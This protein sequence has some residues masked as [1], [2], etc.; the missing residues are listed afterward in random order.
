MAFSNLFFIFLF[1]PLCIGMYFIANTKYRNAVLIAF[2]L[3]FYAWGEPVY[4][5]LLLF[6]TC[7]N[8]LFGKMISFSSEDAPKLGLWLGLLMNIGFLAGIK[9]TG[10]FIENINNLFNAAIKVPEFHFP[11]GISFFTLRA[12][13]YLVDCYWGKIKAEKSFSSFL[14]YMSLFPITT[15]GPVVRYETIALQLHSRETSIVDFSEGLGRLAVGLAKKVLI[16]DQLGSIV[17]QF[18]GGGSVEK[19]TVLGAW[20]GVIMFSLQIYFDFSGYSDMAIGIGRIFGF[21]FEENFNYPFMC[22]DVSE[23]WRRW[24]ISLSTFFRDYV[25]Y[26]PIFGKRRKFGGLFLVWLCMGLWHGASWNFVIWGLYN[27]VFL[28]LEMIV[29]KKN[30]N[31]IPPVVRQIYNKLII[32][33]GFCI[34][35]FTDLGELGM[36]LKNMFFMGSGKFTD[37]LLS[38]S[39][40][41][42]IILIAAA[43]IGCLPLFEN[44]KKRL[45]NCR[46]RNTYMAVQTMGTAAAVALIIV[47]GIFLANETNRPFIYMQF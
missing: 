23:F 18:L 25:L 20:Y 7:M 14:L 22:K 37:P 43:V 4:I 19:Q 47:S 5:W 2:S 28:A 27:G 8:F 39:I 3:V 38:A 42:N 44:L 36:C 34:F 1:L 46:D 17:D 29:G 35:Y 41:S 26:I 15:Q 10:F 32:A 31:T 45:Q 11:I 16:A 33:V 30:M 40:K 21:K 6:V 24:H 13:S 9:Y 12:V